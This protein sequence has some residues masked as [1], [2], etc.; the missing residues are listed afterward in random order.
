MSNTYFQFK[1]FKVEQ[2]NCAMKVS[3]D[4]CIQGAWSPLMPN[5]KHVLDIGTGTG[6]LSLMLAQRHPS[7]SIDA[8]ELDATAA[9]QAQ[10]NFSNAPWSNRLH[11]LQGDAIIYPF[12]KKYDYIICN[13]PFFNNSLLGPEQ[14]RNQARHSITLSYQQLV[15]LLKNNLTATGH[16]SILLPFYE[17]THLWTSLLEEAGMHVIHALHITPSINKPPNRIVFI[18]SLSHHENLTSDLIH[19]RNSDQNYSD[20]FIRLLQPFYASL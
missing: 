5:T 10:E 9:R 13:P 1:Q 2:A 14:Q 8:I 16:A 18:C 3:T 20:S 7:I 17:G 11:L 12:N 19:I 15:S 4:A 6:L